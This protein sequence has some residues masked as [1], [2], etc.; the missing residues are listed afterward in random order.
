MTT[1]EQ[2][3]L[4]TIE[5]IRKQKFPELP[6]DLV[7]QIVLIEKD[8]TDNRQEAFRRISSVIDE[9][10]NNNPAAKKAEG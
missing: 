6:A 2:E 10:L 4:D 5:D 7:K 1:P 3:L 9:Y 8:F